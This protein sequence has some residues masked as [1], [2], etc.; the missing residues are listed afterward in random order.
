MDKDKDKQPKTVKAFLK[1]C[2]EIANTNRDDLKGISALTE[3]E[4]ST[5]GYIRAAVQN[6][7]GENSDFL[8]KYNLKYNS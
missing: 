4:Y 6:D 1:I 7:L 3:E 8:A 5:L 2:L